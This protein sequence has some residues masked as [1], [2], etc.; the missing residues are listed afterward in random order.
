MEC[1]SHSYLVFAFKFR[2][3]EIATVSGFKSSR[4]TPKPVISPNRTAF[5]RRAADPGANGPVPRRLHPTPRNQTRKP[6]FAGYV[7][8]VPAGVTVGSRKACGSS[9]NRVSE[10]RE[11]RAWR[12]RC[13]REIRRLAAHVKTH[14]SSALY[15]WLRERMSITTEMPIG[16]PWQAQQWP[17]S[18]SCARGPCCPPR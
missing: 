17:R 3:R 1:T 15:E 7:P 9:S 10:Q 2:C 8:V 16:A 18:T 4:D 12:S 11:P 13:P 6:T 5:E 14:P